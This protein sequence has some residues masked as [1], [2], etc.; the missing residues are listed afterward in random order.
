[1]GGAECAVNAL[2]ACSKKSSNGSFETYGPFAV[3]MEENYAS[4]QVPKG[5]SA[6]NSFS[7]N[8]SLAEPAINASVQECTKDS[9]LAAED[10]LECFYTSEDKMLQEMAEAT[11]PHITIPFVR[12]MQCDGSWSIMEIPD[13]D[14][15]PE[16]LL[17]DAVCKAP[18]EVSDAAKQCAQ[19]SQSS[20]AVV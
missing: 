11:V 20:V 4:I 16:K 15:L 7:E 13:D 8:R 9:T 18:C 1:M 12:I 17:I 2:Q 14:V 3:C 10:L 6:N 19:L 5:A